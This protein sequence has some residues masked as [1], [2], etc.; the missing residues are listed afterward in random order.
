MKKEAIDK[1]NRLTRREFTEDELYIFPVTLCD[2]DIDRD[3]ERFSDSA[4]EELQKLY[5]GKTGIFDHD[6]TASNQSARIYDTEVIKDSSQCTKDGREYKYLRAWAYMVRTEENKSLIAEID[7]GI[8]KEVSVGCSAGEKT[9]SIC[10]ADIHDTMC[11]HIKGHEYDGAICHHILDGINDAYE[12]SFVAVP[13]QKNAG[14]T[15]KYNPK[16]EKTMEKFTPITTQEELD[17]A[18]KSAVDTAVAETEARF[19]GWVSPEEHQ[20]EIDSITAEKK[21]FELKSLKLNA[22]IK[23]GLP[24]ALAERISGETEEEILKDAEGLAELTM[25]S[26]HHPRRFSTESNDTMSGVEKEFYAKNPDLK[27]I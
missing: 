7:A 22:A 1:I 24:I 20:K 16:E 13:A 18:I 10:G 27:R 5:I 26:V 23:T 15:K 25:K 21:S 11:E 14:V 19:S 17:K 4:L 2:N 8:K 9:C 3:Y 6:P 12:W